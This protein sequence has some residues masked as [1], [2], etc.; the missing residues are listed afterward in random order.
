[1]FST[2][3]ILFVEYKILLSDNKILYDNKLVNKLSHKFQLDI[4]IF[5]CIIIKFKI[6]KNKMLNVEKFLPI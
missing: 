1:M 5:N 6:N 4:F 2:N 3:L